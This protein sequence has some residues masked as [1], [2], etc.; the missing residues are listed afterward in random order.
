MNNIYIIRRHAEAKP[1]HGVAVDEDGRAILSLE[2]ES[3]SDFRYKCGL[4][5]AGRHGAFAARY[6]AGFRL[7]E[8]IGLEALRRL[9][10]R[11]APRQARVDAETITR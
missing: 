1:A 2:T 9:Q 5:N 7:V 6:P 11:G 4:S 3:V 8:V 10:E